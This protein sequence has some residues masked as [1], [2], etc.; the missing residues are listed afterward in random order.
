M[1]ADEP[2]KAGDKQETELTALHDRLRQLEGK[3]DEL[4]KAVQEHLSSLNRKKP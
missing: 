3:L 1:A 2:Q 4:R